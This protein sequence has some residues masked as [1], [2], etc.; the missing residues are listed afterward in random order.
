MNNCE[1]RFS[2]DEICSLTDTPRRR[3]RFYIQEGVVSPPMGVKRG[4]YYTN[5]HLEQILTIKKWQQAG[6]SL[7]RIRELL[8][9]DSNAPPFKPRSK[10]SVEVWS[11]LVLDDGIELHIE[12]SRAALSPEALRKLSSCIAQLYSTI[13]EA[14]QQGEGNE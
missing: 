11:H 10:G 4:A 7:E 12:P 9:N 2:V 5:E 6:L 8:H 1:Q 13:K 14:P 3:L